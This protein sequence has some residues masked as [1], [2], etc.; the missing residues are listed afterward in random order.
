M[1]A[2]ANSKIPET[3]DKYFV[4]DRNYNLR[5]DLTKSL[6]FDF[7]ATNNSRVDEPFGR[8]DTKA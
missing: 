3:Y 7:R 5:W 6:N 4:V 8:I 2:E 1:W